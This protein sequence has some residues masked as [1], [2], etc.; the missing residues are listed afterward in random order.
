MADAV[1][2]Q[3][4]QMENDSTLQSLLTYLMELGKAKYTKLMF[5]P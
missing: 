2:T 1:S 5:L 3:V 4:L